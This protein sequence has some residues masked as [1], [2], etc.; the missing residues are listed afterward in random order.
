MNDQ[1]PPSSPGP[2]PA[3]RAPRGVRVIPAP[4]ASPPAPGSIVRMLIATRGWTL[5]CAFGLLIVGVLSAL[6]ANK[7]WRFAR[8]MDRNA[9][10]DFGSLEKGLVWLD[11]GFS[12]AFAAGC[13]YVVPRL[14]RYAGAI[15]RLRLASRMHELENALRHQ[16]AVWIVLG[17][18][19]ALWFVL[20]TFQIVST[21]M[22]FSAQSEEDA[23]TYEWQPGDAP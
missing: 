22:A 10:A 23:D 9:W 11:I 7:Q 18:L 17:S 12:A 3:A 4:G 8:L 19:A 6:H 13:F 2:L 1:P 20:F 16:R 5:V 15:S 21:V 14:L